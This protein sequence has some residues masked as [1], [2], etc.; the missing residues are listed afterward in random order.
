MFLSKNGEKI[1][2][3]TLPWYD[4]F[5]SFFYISN[6]FISNTRLKLAKN[7]VKAGQH[8]QAELSSFMLSSKINMKYSEKYAKNKSVCFN[9]II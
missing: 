8:L 6:T 7:Q 2:K 3:I 9:E 1:T 5:F 4:F